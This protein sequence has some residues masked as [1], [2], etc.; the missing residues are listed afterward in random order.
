MNEEKVF[1]IVAARARARGLTCVVRP[2]VPPYHLRFTVLEVI[3]YS[4]TPARHACYEIEGIEI[5]MSTVP[6]VLADYVAET[7]FRM[8]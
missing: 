8:L 7:L 5:D 1:G 2:S 6:E 3:D 4:V